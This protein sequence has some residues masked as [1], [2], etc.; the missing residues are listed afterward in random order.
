MPAA[1]LTK[2]RIPLKVGFVALNDCA[3]LLMARELGLFAKYDLQ[4]ELSREVGWATIRDKILYGELDAA[5]AVAGLPLSCT[6]GIGS[7]ARDC[8]TG[9]VLNLHGNAITLSQSLWQRGVRDAPTL[10]QTI[11]ACR[12]G[13]RLVFGVASSYSSHNFILRQWLRDAGVDPAA[14]VEIVTVPPAQMHG[15]LRAGNLD[16]YCVG[17]P[18]NSLAVLHR[19]GWAVATSSELAPLHPE[20]VLLVRRQFADERSAQHLALIASL[21]EAC[22]FC[23]RPENRERVLETLSLSEN[24]DAPI[25]ALRRSMC[26]TFD[27]GHDRVEKITD[28]HVFSR[29]NANEPTEQKGAW[30]LRQMIASGLLEDPGDV[31]PD[32]LAR[33]FRADLFHEAR[34]LIAS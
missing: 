7:I 31:P 19:T 22:A 8:L 1:F 6:L 25:H 17:E 3:P 27:F 33:T 32:L 4:V 13:Q 12:R 16:G 34:R 5:Q 15:N 2:A 30:V 21:I 28:F 20:K 10:Q 29:S 9:L 14:D 23:D 18:W 24:V 26:G 11:L